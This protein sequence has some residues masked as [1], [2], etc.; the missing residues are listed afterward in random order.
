MNCIKILTDKD[1]NITPIE[2]GKPRIRKGSRGILFNQNGKI[3]IINKIVKNEFKL[4]GGG[5]ENDELPEE[6]FVREAEE[7]AGAIIKNIKLLGTFEEHKSQ[8]N[9]KQISYVYKAEVDT[10]NPSNFTENEKRD[11]AKLIWLYPNDALRKIKECEDKLKPSN[12]EGELSI[13]HT[14][15]IVRRDY[16]IL[17]YYIENYMK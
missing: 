7:E 5:I 13:Y 16:E 12:C 6:T 1:F 2:F 8:D 4:I 11:K 10:L 17:K 3:A 15:F 9:F 14:K